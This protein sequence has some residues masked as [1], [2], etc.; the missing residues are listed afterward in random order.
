[1]LDIVGKK[2]KGT[3]GQDMSEVME[4]DSHMILHMPCSSQTVQYLDS[5]PHILD[6]TGPSDNDE[7]IMP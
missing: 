5:N 1:M 6:N 4:N 7:T 2:E 3:L